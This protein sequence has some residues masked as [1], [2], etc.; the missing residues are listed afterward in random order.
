MLTEGGQRAATTS[1][2]QP[3]S[4]Q[5]NINRTRIRV[6]L[7]ETQVHL[8]ATSRMPAYDRDARG[9]GYTPHCVLC[10]HALSLGRFRKRLSVTP[11]RSYTLSR[12]EQTPAL[13]LCGFLSAEFFLQ[14]HAPLLVS[15]LILQYVLRGFDF[16]TMR[17][18]HRLSVTY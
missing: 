15:R 6:H 12:T 7:A 9:R 11:M 13:V 1:L 16:V 3:L 2:T 18:A 8:G 17:L 10:P 4:C 14:T 5:L